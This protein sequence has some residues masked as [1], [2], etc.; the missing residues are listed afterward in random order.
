[1][2]AERHRN[3][4]GEKE[5]TEFRAID[6]DWRRCGSRLRS[7]LQLY[8]II[9]ERHSNCSITS[10]HL[11]RVYVCMSVRV[12][13]DDGS[14]GQ[15]LRL[16]NPLCGCVA[17]THL[18]RCCNVIG[19]V[20]VFCCHTQFGHI[21]TCVRRSGLCEWSITSQPKTNAHTNTHTQKRQRWMFCWCCGGRLLADAALKAWFTYLIRKHYTIV[22]A[23]SKYVYTTHGGCANFWLAT[24]EY[25]M[26]SQT[27]F[28]HMLFTMC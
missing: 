24:N 20:G 7:A 21:V 9:Y 5:L 8:I 10:H 16:S 15:R 28:S 11:S 2:R 22:R 12:R 18:K 3:G 27:H 14:R 19:V 26:F 6:G 17:Q 23:K 13:M 1:M 25:A 4:C